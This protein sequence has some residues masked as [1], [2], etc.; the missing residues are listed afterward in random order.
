MIDINNKTPK[1]LRKFC[2]GNDA[3]KRSKKPH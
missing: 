3:E 1:I 2:R